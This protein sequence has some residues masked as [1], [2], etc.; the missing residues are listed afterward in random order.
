MLQVYHLRLQVHE[1]ALHA[2]LHTAQG[3]AYAVPPSCKAGALPGRDMEGEG[4]NKRS[5]HTRP[6]RT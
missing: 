2:E 3:R 6:L 1:G 4:Q 5:A